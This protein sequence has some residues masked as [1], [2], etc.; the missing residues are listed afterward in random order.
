M[1]SGNLLFDATQQ[2]TIDGSLAAQAPSGGR[3]GTVDI[4]SPTDIRILGPSGS[5]EAGALNL[6]AAALSAFGA[7]SLLI[8]GKRSPGADGT[9]VTAT[10]ANITVDNAGSPLTG[11]DV[12]LVANQS[13]TLAPS[14][15]ISQTGTLSGAAD[16]LIIGN[17]DT[18]GSGNG[19]L[20][21]P[22][23]GSAQSAGS[24]SGR[25]GSSCS[26]RT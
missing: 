25:R 12:I 24:C 6:D 11:P 7:E 20:R 3:G 1:D 19:V 5:T 9:V 23:P 8:G 22:V 18:A 16:T 15:V 17:A 21:G 2:M 10:T 26:P 4:S 14:S 13:I